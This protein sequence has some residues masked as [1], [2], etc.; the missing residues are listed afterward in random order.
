MDMIFLIIVIM[1]TE[2]LERRIG[3][4]SSRLFI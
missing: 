3:K 2:I 1:S 4:R